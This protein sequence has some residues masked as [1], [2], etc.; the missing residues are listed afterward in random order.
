MPRG[1]CCGPGHRPEPA[2]LAGVHVGG[3]RLAP[4]PDSTVLQCPSWRGRSPFQTLASW[5]RPEVNGSC[6]IAKFLV[7]L[8]NPPSLLPL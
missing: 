6:V 1:G 8:G 4:L 3:P 7:T 5:L 2:E